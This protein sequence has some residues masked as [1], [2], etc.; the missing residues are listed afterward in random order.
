MSDYTKDYQK[1]LKFLESNL[2]VIEVIIRRSVDSLIKTFKKEIK[3]AIKA[4][5]Q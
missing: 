5:K 3:L 4:W 2:D 1:F